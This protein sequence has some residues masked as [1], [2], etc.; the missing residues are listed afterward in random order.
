MGLAMF[1]YILS[2]LILV[3]VV[4]A[5]VRMDSQASSTIDP[6]SVKLPD[7]SPALNVGKTTYD[8]FC[9]SCHGENTA[10]TDK[11]PTF[12]HKVYH[13]GHHGDVAFLVAPMKGAKAHHWGFGDMLPVDGV[14]ESHL[15]KIVTYVRAVQKAN[16]IY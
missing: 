10:G 13:P 9:A 6:A 1:K 7:M 8:A 15:K 14:T 11:G 12:L 16:G 4:L 5:W 2:G 3:A